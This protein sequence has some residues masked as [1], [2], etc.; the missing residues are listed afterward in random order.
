[1][2]DGGKIDILAIDADG[3]ITVCECTLQTNAASGARLS[4]RF[5]CTPPR[6]DHLVASSADQEE[7]EP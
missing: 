5:S 7:R 6:W 4:G 2:P 3:V 1:M